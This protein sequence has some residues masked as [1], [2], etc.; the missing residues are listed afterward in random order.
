MEH[1]PVVPGYTVQH[2]EKVPCLCKELY[3]GGPFLSYA[4]TKGKDHIIEA[5]G[6]S[7]RQN[8]KL[9]PDLGNELEAFCQEWLFFGVIDELLR[10]Y[11][12]LRDFVRTGDD[13][14]KWVSGSCSPNMLCRAH[15][16]P[17]YARMVFPLYHADTPIYLCGN[18]LH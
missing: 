1:L 14:M 13:G 5:A 6:I 4:T 15:M 17:Q 12:T 10:D 3:D 8:K 7:L 11:C 18:R 2:L 16:K 9:S